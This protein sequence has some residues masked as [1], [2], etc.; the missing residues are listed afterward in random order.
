MPPSVCSNEPAAG[1]SSRPCRRSC[2]SGRRA[3]ARLPG[4]AARPTRP[5]RASVV[6]L[7]VAAASALVLA[8]VLRPSHVGLVPVRRKP[9]GQVG[10]PD[11]Y[12]DLVDAVAVGR[13]LVLAA[14]LALLQRAV[15]PPPWRPAG[16]HRDV[17]RPGADLAG[18]RRPGSPVSVRA[19]PS[20]EH[21]GGGG[22]VLLPVLYTVGFATQR[23]SRARVADLLL[24]AREEHDPA[25]LRDLVARAIG[26]PRAGLAWWDRR[27]ARYL[28]H[29]GRPVE[30]VPG[31][32]I[33]VEAVGRTDCRRAVRARR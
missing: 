7:V 32:A 14:G 16:V 18:R 11:T 13:M 30:P 28:D 4:R 26:D 17:R 31:E 15:A 27:E 24:A 2:P 23:P 12:L 21:R 6:G 8:G 33:A 10:A 3:R 5:D 29:Q 19:R 20:C 1:C 9:A 22:L 25:R